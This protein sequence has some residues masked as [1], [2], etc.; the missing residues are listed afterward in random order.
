[1]TVAPGREVRVGAGDEQEPL[2]PT[3]LG[4]SRLA[5]PQQVAVAGREA[6]LDAGALELDQHHERIVVPEE[7]SRQVDLDHVVDRAGPERV[8][9]RGTQRT[10]EPVG[11]VLVPSAPSRPDTA[12]TPRW[13]NST[14]SEPDCDLAATEE[15]GRTRPTAGRAAGS[16]ARP[17][18][19]IVRNAPIDHTQ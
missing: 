19:A 3:R 1:M 5:E 16:T 9:H 4:A 14:T 13:R 7:R 6:E 12:A 18:T 10:A 2:V 15:R 17:P 11:L 8:V